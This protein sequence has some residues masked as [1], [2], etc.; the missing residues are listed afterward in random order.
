MLTG[1]E[2]E[3]ISFKHADDGDGDGDGTPLV[4]VVKPT[5]EGPTPPV[6][7]GHS[8]TPLPAS[9]SSVDGESTHMKGGGRPSC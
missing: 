1:P 2:T 6:R 8:C 7:M 3:Q 4:E 5:A 9:A